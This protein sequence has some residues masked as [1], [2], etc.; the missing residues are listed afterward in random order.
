MA[1]NKIVETAPKQLWLQINPEASRNEDDTFEGADLPFP[2]G[3]EITW[4]GERIGG[5]EIEYTRA[6]LATGIPLAQKAWEAGFIE[7]CKWFGGITQDVDSPAAQRSR[8]TQ[9][10]ILQANLQ[11]L[12]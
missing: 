8:N 4:C 11:D 5:L 1:I 9:I 7:A 6:D 2:Y 12:S 3:E 10:A